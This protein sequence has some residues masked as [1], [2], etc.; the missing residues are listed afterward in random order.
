MAPYQVSIL[1][2]IESSSVIVYCQRG[3]RTTSLY[4]KNS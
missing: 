3:L 4:D 1:C 2:K